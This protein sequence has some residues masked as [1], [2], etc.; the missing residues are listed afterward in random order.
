MEWNNP[1]NSF[2][3][4]KGLLYR[5]QFDGIISGN[6]KPPVEVNI[7][8]VNNCQLDCVW[9]NAKNIIDKDKKV[10]MTKDHLF[11]LIDYSGK[12]GVKAICI[13]GGGE[14]TLMPEVG[15][16]FERIVFNG[17]ESAIITNG[18]F[19]NEDQRFGIAKYTRWCGVSVDCSNAATYNKLKKQDKFDTVISNMSKLVDLDIKELTYKFL[20]HPDNQY[21]IYTACKLAKDIGCN[22][23]HTRIL[24]TQYLDPHAYYDYNAINVQL[25]ACHA[26]E[27]KRFKVYTISHKQEGEGNRRI[28]F[29]S[30]NASPLLCMFEANGDISLCIDRKGDPA[31][32]LGSHENVEDIGRLWGSQHHKEI[33]SKICPNKDCKKCTMTI[34][35][36]LL[37]AYWKDS[38]CVNF[39]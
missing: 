21:E 4:Y 2:N 15:E 13:A 22:V 39:P 8:P 6:L 30:C 29:D 10:M 11:D 28:R 14:P 12:W 33:L 31:V 1:Y 17:M 23:F 9:C 16:A 18:L 35:Q 32:R 38:F 5:D 3:S 37:D 19:Q 36:E 7:D 26:L 34:Y 25:K 20:I 24:S 27:D